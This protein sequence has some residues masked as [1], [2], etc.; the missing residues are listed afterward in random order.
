MDLCLFV[1]EALL[2]F[3]ILS[4]DEEQTTYIPKS[5]RPKYG[6]LIAQWGQVLKTW[7][8]KAQICIEEWR[9]MWDIPAPEKWCLDPP[10]PVFG[11]TYIGVGHITRY[12]VP[13]Y[14]VPVI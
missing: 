3:N 6:R 5:H 11:P 9:R 2:P 7:I 8:K 1:L 10:T 12:Q 4:H 13:Y 14:E